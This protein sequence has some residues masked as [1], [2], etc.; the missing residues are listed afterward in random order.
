MSAIIADLH[1][2]SKF[3][4]AVSKKMG[5]EEIAYWARLKGIN[6]VA[7][8]DWTHPL[9]FREIKKKLKVITPGIFQLEKFPEVKF[10]LVTE[11]STVYSH[12]EKLRKIHHLIF[13]PSFEVAEKIIKKLA[14][15]GYNLL[16]DGRPTIGLSSRELLELIMDINENTFLIPCHIWTPWFSLFGSRSGY[17]SIEE[18]FED[19]STY[20]TAVETGLS[21]D[22]VMNWQ[23]KELTNRVIVSFSDAH[24]GSKLGREATVFVFNNEQAS[25]PEAYSFSDI[26]NALKQKPSRLKIGYTIEFFPQEGKYHWSG[27]RDCRVRYSPEEVLKKGKICPVCQRQLTIGVENRVIEL[28]ERM[29]KKDD[30]CFLKNRSG[31]TFVYDKEKKRTPFVSIVPLMEILQQITDSPAKAEK[32]YFRLIN[33]LGPEFL[34]ILNTPYEKI[35]AVGGRTLKEA[36]RNV[37][38]REVKVEPG[39]DGVFG[40]VQIFSRKE[41]PEVQTSQLGL[42]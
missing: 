37:R 31:L 30:L 16:A 11:I 32:D 22:P 14:G 17:D 15:F 36:I 40:K 42:F 4:Q 9:W 28:S 21:S 7:T 5:L 10:M 39:Y 13:S 1:L 27:H 19:L 25:K 38:E 18:S 3:S 29:I 12:K 20:I 6:L 23:I 24:S 2:H 41:K 8:G 35:E 34:I 26:L 33:E